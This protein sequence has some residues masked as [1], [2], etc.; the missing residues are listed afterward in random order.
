MCGLYATIL[1][2]AQDPHTIFQELRDANKNGSLVG[3][4]DAKEYGHFRRLIPLLENFLK[5]APAARSTVW[6]LIQYEKRR[7]LNRLIP[8]L[9]N[10]LKTAPA[11]RSTVWR[12]IQYKKR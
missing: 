8:L 9:E 10:F 12:L 1:K 4:F 11:A 6:R 2:E 3:L 5:T 7:G